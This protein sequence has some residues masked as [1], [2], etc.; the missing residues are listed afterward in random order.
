MTLGVLLVRPGAAGAGRDNPLFSAARHDHAPPGP[1]PDFHTQGLVDRPRSLE[2]PRD[3]IAR[4]LIVSS[5][6]YVYVY[7]AAL[8]CPARPLCFRATTP[9][10]APRYADVV[11]CS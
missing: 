6:V 1:A 2:G 10:H 3:L 8:R 7:S 5:C 11:L 9:R 4:V